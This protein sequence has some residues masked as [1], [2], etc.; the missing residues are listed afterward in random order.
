MRREFIYPHRSVRSFPISGARLCV[1]LGTAILLCTLVVY[2][3]TALLVIHGRFSTFLLEKTRIPSSGMKM[4]EVYPHLGPVNTLDVPFPAQ[5]AHPVRTGVIFAVFLLGLIL[6]HRRFPLSRNF[7]VFLIVLLCT[8]GGV[9]LLNQSFNFDSSMYE[10]IWLRGEILV[11]ILL[12][13]VSAFLF[14]L[15]VPSVAAGVGWALLI[16]VYAIF[17]SAL[18][19]AF[20]LGVLHFTGILF[21][22]LL[23]F[24]LGILFDLVYV[25]V[26]YSLALQWSMKRAMGERQS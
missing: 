19:L 5:R 1:A 18:R 26:F 21:L 2:F 25:L 24:C 16:Q 13:W 12:P 15:T 22:P 4:L 3:G 14:I 6:I 11:W 17:W 20:C 7:I 10:R 23:W 9:I 8:A